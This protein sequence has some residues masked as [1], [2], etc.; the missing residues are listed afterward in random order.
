MKRRA[1][2]ICLTAIIITWILVIKTS[3]SGNLKASSM[4][5]LGYAAKAVSPEHGGA[6]SGKS[7][8]ISALSKVIGEDYDEAKRGLY[9]S[10]ATVTNYILQDR[11][12]YM[13]G[14][15]AIDSISTRKEFTETRRAIENYNEALYGKLFGESKNIDKKGVRQHIDKAMFHVNKAFSDE[16]FRLSKK[17]TVMKH[18]KKIN[19]WA[20]KKDLANMLGFAFDVISLRVSLKLLKDSINSHEEVKVSANLLGICAG[21][22]GLDDFV[23]AVASQIE[24]LDEKGPLVGALLSIAVTFAK[25]HQNRKMQTEE[26]TAKVGY[27]SKAIIEKLGDTSKRQ[28]DRLVSHINGVDISLNDIY[29]VNKGLLPKWGILYGKD[30]G[31]L[32]FGAFEDGGAGDFPLYRKQDGSDVFLIGGKPRRITKAQQPK[33]D[34]ERELVGFDF[35]GTFAK[36]YPYKGSTIFVSTDGVHTPDYRLNGLR[37]NTC[38][39]KPWFHPNDHLLLTD[40]SNLDLGER[41]EVDMGKGDD[42]LII[43]GMFGAFSNQSS[44]TNEST[45]FVDLGSGLNTLSFEGMS[46][47]R[48]DI[49]G[50]FFDRKD[51]KLSYFHGKNAKL[52]AI[53]TIKFV[54]VLIGSPFH[55]YVILSGG[56]ESSPNGNDFTAVQH[57]GA[58]FYEVD[59]DQSLESATKSRFKVIDNSKKTPT[60]VIRTSSTVKRNELVFAGNVLKI[61]RKKSQEAQAE[62]TVRVHIIS[63]KIPLI[64]VVDVNDNSLISDI[65]ANFLA[66]EYVLGLSMVTKGRT[67]INGSNHDDVCVLECQKKKLGGKDD[68]VITVDLGNG[69]DTLVL[70]D[71][72]FLEPCEIN[73]KDYT[74]WLD[75]ERGGQ[76][77]GNWYIYVER[78]KKET[79]VKRY[80]LKGIE[81]IVNAFGS[82]IVN[83]SNEKMEK[84]NLLDTFISVTSHEIGLFK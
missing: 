4:E 18:L 54:H 64:K 21:M 24:I 27:E 65:R 6:L 11:F 5:A 56:S 32:Q 69:T 17:S 61:F 82:L 50:I 68:D 26:P 48:K 77:S 39:Q 12:L 38:L 75:P 71:S 33:G 53:G 29:V 76:V 35:Y 7:S 19:T 44:E 46:R 62:E 59:L 60:I 52:H 22:V 74:I 67:M 79:V 73:D 81:K 3:A 14:K 36:G 72:T 28:L 23:S 55:D 10:V 34:E 58:N 57:E 43:N 15:D 49:E 66:P 70:K 40:M 31:P 16:L 1:T 47:Q 80:L 9:E 78:K 42:V 84:I 51:S 45:L 63:K 37:I 25:I 8:I 13:I 30:R 83:L 2:K 41:I 20:R